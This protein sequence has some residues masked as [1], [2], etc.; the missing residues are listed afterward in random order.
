M[1]TL[2]GVINQLLTGLF[3]LIAWPLWG[4]G[5][6]AFL[7]VISFLSALVALVI[8]GRFSNQEAIHKVRNRIRG[9][10]LAVRLYRDSVPVVLALQL[11]II[12]D[13]WTYI[14][15]SL[16]SLPVLILPFVLILV[17]LDLHL[18]ARALQPG[19]SAVV[20]AKFSR[21]LEPADRVRLE[22]PQAITVETPPVKLPA[23]KEVVWRIRAEAPTR[24]VLALHW[25]DEVIEKEV[26]VGREGGAVSSLRTG[27]M[28][29]ML[30]H[31]GEA[32]IRRSLEVESVQ[33]N[34]PERELSVWG[35]NVDWMILFFVFCCLFAFACKGFLGVEI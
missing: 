14:R 24:D 18:T 22:S 17:Q 27:N 4:L 9:N 8:F 5:A 16:V 15:Y 10:M 31:P 32:P 3:G 28:M 13:T 21:A 12:R 11:R 26:V 29:E 19:E 25:G 20:K 6:M 2:I 35:W 7:V 1:S 23:L 30:L 33:I 34:Y